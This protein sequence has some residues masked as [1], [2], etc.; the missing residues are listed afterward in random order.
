MS[1]ASW[2]KEFFPKMPKRG[3]VAALQHSIR[4]WKGLLPKNLK[5]HGVYNFYPGVEERDEHIGPSLE[6]SSQ[7]CALC[8]IYYEPKNAG[9]DPGW[10][11]GCERCPIYKLRGRSCHLEWKKAHDEHPDSC[12]PM[13]KLLEGVLKKYRKS[14]KKGK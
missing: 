12:L 9:W 6:F 11:P 7:N 14:Q 10:D 13:I 5:K 3:V 2:K 8:R 4:K 1:L